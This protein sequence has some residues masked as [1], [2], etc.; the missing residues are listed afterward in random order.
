MSPI[1]DIPGRISGLA[2]FQVHQRKKVFDTYNLEGFT[3]D[4]IMCVGGVGL[5]EPE[6]FAFSDL[7]LL[8]QLQIKAQFLNNDM[9][10]AVGY[11]E[12]TEDTWKLYPGSSIVFYA[13]YLHDGIFEDAL[14][15]PNNA[16]ITT[17]PSVT[18]DKDPTEE[19]FGIHVNEFL[20][21]ARAHKVPLM[22]AL[23][24][25]LLNM[26][27]PRVHS[28]AERIGLNENH[29][30][31]I[32]S[33]VEYNSSEFHLLTNMRQSG[34][35]L[36]RVP[37]AGSRKGFISIHDSVMYHDDKVVCAAVPSIDTI[38]QFGDRGATAYGHVLLDN[39]EYKFNVPVKDFSSAWFERFCKD[40][41]YM[42]QITSDI[43]PNFLHYINSFSSPERVEGIS[44]VGWDSTR[45]SFIFPNH[46][47][48]PQGEIETTRIPVLGDH[49]TS[50]I[51]LHD[52]ITV[53]DVDT[54]L[55]DIPGTAPYIASLAGAIACVLSPAE[56]YQNV[57]VNAYSQNYAVQEKL[58][59]H[60][61]EEC[62]FAPHSYIAKDNEDVPGDGYPVSGILQSC[63]D[64]S[65]VLFDLRDC[66]CNMFA[67]LDD[68]L[69]QLSALT[70][71]WIS[72]DVS[73]YNCEGIKSFS[74]KIFAT[75]LRAY[76]KDKK[77]LNY[78]R[79]YSSNLNHLIHGVLKF[80]GTEFKKVYP[81][82]HNEIKVN[83][84]TLIEE[85][86]KLITVDLPIKGD[87][88]KRFLYAVMYM[89][90]ARKLGKSNAEI[91]PLKY[92]VNIGSKEVYLNYQSIK[93]HIKHIPFLN[94]I[95]DVT[96]TFTESDALI[97]KIS[98]LGTTEGWVITRE[99]WDSVESDWL[100]L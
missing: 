34:L 21:S 76:L 64:T 82:L 81:K 11:T 13:P 40:R 67:A 53:E 57:M 36:N 28:F 49:P 8:M 60:I 72:V 4:G 5:F 43:K 63:K 56:K 46:S 19:L 79:K 80:I 42:I 9:L 48:N 86:E 89:I 61:T 6:I 20:L 35:V 31:Q 97:T 1:S 25:Y 92:D 10:P 14:K 15:A 12:S 94:N 41:G 85:A 84:D 16:F 45:E 59:Q 77:S 44:S 83:V 50:T 98:S 24:E 7:A 3:N 75:I 65:K 38:V 78:L 93:K 2:T 100:K 17:S 73:N 29:W 27:A 88:G 39:K 99:F 30:R 51:R 74:Y 70:G 33:T 66:S 71:N 87:L 26:S 32:I 47:I 96:R 68:G 22:Q 95:A 23:R 69:Y 55:T 18:E 37:A 62:L 54:I 91:P 90:E 58:F 52:L